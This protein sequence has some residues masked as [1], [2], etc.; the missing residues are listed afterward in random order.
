M[1]V[2]DGGQGTLGQPGMGSVRESAVYANGK[3]V[4]FSPGQL[5]GHPEPLFHQITA[6]SGAGELCKT[7]PSH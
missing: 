3:R 4:A 7:T 5:Q 2:S 6:P 1:A